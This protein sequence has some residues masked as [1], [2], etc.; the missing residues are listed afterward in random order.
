MVVFI[1]KTQ[2]KF[3]L[4]DVIRAVDGDKI[5]SGCGL[6]LAECSEIEPVRFIKILRRSRNEMHDMLNNAKLGEFT[7]HLDNKLSFLK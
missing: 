2:L 6:G 3:S 5:F 7:E 1:W 4:A